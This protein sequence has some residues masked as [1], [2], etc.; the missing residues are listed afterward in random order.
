MTNISNQIAEATQKKI[1]SQLDD[2]ITRDV[3]H[4]AV[5]PSSFIRNPDGTLNFVQTVEL[6][7]KD[8]EYVEYLEGENKRLRD[9]LKG[10]L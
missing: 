8:R 2:F 5:G 9:L 1:L 7:L 6:K 3:I 10:K 4:V